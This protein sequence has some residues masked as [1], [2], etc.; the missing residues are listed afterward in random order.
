MRTQPGKGQKASWKLGAVEHCPSQT[1]EQG[2]SPTGVLDTESLSGMNVPLCK[3]LACPKAGCGVA[4]PW[5]PLPPRQ[6]IIEAQSQCQ[7]GF[8]ELQSIGV[9]ASEGVRSLAL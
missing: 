9:L 3:I 7:V 4:G 8:R 2:A 1:E 5:K 6:R